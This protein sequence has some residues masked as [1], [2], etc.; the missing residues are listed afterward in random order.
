MDKNFIKTSFVLMLCQLSAGLF[1]PY[2]SLFLVDK[3]GFNNEELGMYVLICGISSFVLNLLVGVKSDNML[4]TKKTVLLF[5][6]TM[7]ILGYSFLVFTQS[8]FVILII[9]VIFISFST[10]LTTQIFSYAKYILKGDKE[11]YYISLLRIVVS[12]SWIVSPVIAS[13]I[14]RN[15]NY[16]LLVVGVVFWYLLSLFACIFLFSEND[17]C[18]EEITIEKTHIKIRYI[19]II[20]SFLVFSLLQ[21]TNTI[22]N[23]NVPLY[24]IEHINVSKS[25]IGVISSINAIMEIPIII[26]ISKLLDKCKVEKIIII[27]IVLGSTLFVIFPQIDNMYIVLI[28]MTLKAA[29]GTSFIAL[30]MVF[31]HKTIPERIGLATALYSNTNR[32]GSMIAGSIISLIGKNYNKMF[33]ILLIISLI[34]MFYFICIVNKNKIYMRGE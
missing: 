21:A 11:D 7:S 28:L 25:F 8:F 32:V 34:C 19:Y 26:I 31:F 29:Y 22:W 5:S 12:I 33:T 18:T 24:L 20:L 17:R 30:G 3:V 10:T 27:G 16:C 2:L 6:L 4:L 13:I 14:M 1:T 9:S 23:T 15:S